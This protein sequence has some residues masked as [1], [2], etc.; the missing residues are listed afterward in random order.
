MEDAIN[1]VI[2]SISQRDPR[3][4]KE[5]MGE[6]GLLHCSKCHHKTETVIKHP[7]TGE[8]R[9]VRCVCKCRTEMDDF[10]ER[11]KREELERK[12]RI[13]FAES[14][15]SNWTFANDDGKNEKISN[16]MRNYVK[17]FTDFK[18]DGKGLL[19]YGSV[20]TGKTYFAA[21]IANALIDEGY[22]VLMTNFARLTN[23]IQGTFDGKNEF[24]DS[25]QRYTLLIIDDLGAERK[26]E[27]MQET[28][29]NI[30]DA[31]YRSGLPFIITTNLTA[32]EIKKPQEVGYSR[33]YDRILERC[34]PVAV[35]GESRRRQEV[36]DSYF[37][38]K[39]KLG[40]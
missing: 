14:N 9:K 22:S 38:I 25:L 10:N 35:T 33:I 2:D 23:S 37:D 26:S 17:N 24:I 32:E 20:G 3:P 16:A 18:K 7:F 21:C 19:L 36:K 8:E 40:L 27:Y 4:E 31:R 13:C 15:M 5:Y 39:E 6:D 28:V 12:K 34:F 29:F 11:Q 30:I 1:S